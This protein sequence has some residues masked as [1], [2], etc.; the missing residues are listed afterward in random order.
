MLASAI[1]GAR[2]AEILRSLSLWL[3]L[4]VVLALL[5]PGLV[6]LAFHQ[7]DRDRGQLILGTI[8]SN[9]LLIGAALRP[10]LAKADPAQFTQLQAALSPFNALGRRITVLYKPN[11]AI[12]VAGF[13]YVA[14]IPAVAPDAI[15]AEHQFLVDTGVLGR[16]TQACAGNVPLA[17]R[18]D[19][20]GAK[21]ELLTSVSPVIA[22]NG[23]FAVVVSSD[24]AGDVAL[25]DER[26]F[27]ARPATQWA[28]AL[29]AAM[30]LIGLGIFTRVRGGLKNF[31][32][33]AQNADVGAPSFAP[34]FVSATDLP[35]FVPLAREFDQMVTRLN[36]ASRSLR[37]AAEQNAHAL[38][39]KLAT[40]RQLTAALPPETQLA[41]NPALDRLDGLVQSARRLDTATAEALSHHPHRLD[42]SRLVQNFAQ[43]YRQML[44]EA[45]AR[46]QSHIAPAIAVMGDAE[47]F[48]V[49][50][51]NL[52]ENALSFTP[53][54]GQVTI[55]LYR[56]ANGCVLSV[57]DQ[58]SGVKP[59]LLPHIFD[60]YFSSRPDDASPHYGIGLWLV[61]QHAQ[62][63]GGVVE[64]WNREGGG[65]E[66]RVVFR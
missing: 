34:S 8:R 28:L 56:E 19:L 22:P 50:L 60:R 16:L 45:G 32:A 42:L 31:R 66:V 29:Y 13:F 43:S 27:W 24:A 53:P 4:L 46:V 26:A 23:C 30:A 57:A 33:V 40:I 48:E 18:V 14:G 58:G 61:R 41:L 51:E 11:Q 54:P 59:D 25:A 7:L 3:N 36:Q 44:G 47:M 39:G 38:K 63:L 12:G 6:V 15:A 62:A 2:P 9:G 35:E 10:T 55:A 37:E 5:L 52:V 64:A 49:I 17:A 20:P 21:A 1:A 65:L